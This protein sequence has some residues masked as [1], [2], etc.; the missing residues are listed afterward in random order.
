[1]KYRIILVFLLF[2]IISCFSVVYSHP[3]GWFEV[4]TAFVLSDQKITE[5]QTEWTVDEF[6]SMI[7]IEDID[8]N[9]NNKI[10]ANEKIL[11]KERIQSFF[12]ENM[13][14]KDYF[15]FVRINEN[16]YTAYKI[17]NFLASVKSGR[18]VLTF[19][20]KFNKP[21]DPRISKMSVSFYDPSYYY[22]VYFAEKNPVK[23]INDKAKIY[24]YKVEEDLE[25]TYFF[26][27]VNPQIVRVLYKGKK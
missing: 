10:E 16:L 9:K 25:R 23:F 4:K 14:K 18:I 26:N 21:I 1:M 13:K 6:N 2:F 20:I 17:S 27:M 24:S 15:S 19:T 11:F 22:D 7:N 8:I 5:I 3:H 12:L